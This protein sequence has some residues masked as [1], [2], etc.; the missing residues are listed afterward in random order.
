MCD[1]KH[2]K[3]QQRTCAASILILVNPKHKTKFTRSCDITSTSTQNT[4]AEHL[5][6]LNRNKQYKNEQHATAVVAEF[7][8]ILIKISPA[9]NHETRE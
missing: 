3:E 5:L 2:I 4:C 1:T 7:M 9:N 8:T 6:E